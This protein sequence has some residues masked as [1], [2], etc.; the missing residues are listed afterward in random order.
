MYH[1]RNLKRVNNLNFAKFWKLESVSFERY[2][3][4]ASSCRQGNAEFSYLP[5]ET[6]PN[7]QIGLTGYEITWNVT[8]LWITNIYFMIFWRVNPIWFWLNHK[9]FVPSIKWACVGENSSF[10]HICAYNKNQIFIDLND[11]EGHIL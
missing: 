1:L 5:N 2:S 7:S 10:F 8:Q 11:V 9:N 4:S 6:G 3:H